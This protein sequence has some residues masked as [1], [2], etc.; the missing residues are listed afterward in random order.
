MTGRRLERNSGDTGKDE[1]FRKT[2]PEKRATEAEEAKAFEE[3]LGEPLRGWDE[4]IEPSVPHLLELEALVTRHREESGR[5][6]W[7]DL[8]M[9]WLLGILVISGMIL[10]YRWNVIAF[11]VLQALAVAGAVL[12]LAVSSRKNR[13]A[14]RE[15]TT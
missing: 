8:F 9:L 1:G 3:L 11:A 10:L 2:Q 15:W 14:K 6:L 12:F 13:E 4:R 7:R 5:K